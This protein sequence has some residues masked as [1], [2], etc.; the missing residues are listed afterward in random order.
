MHRIQPDRKLREGYMGSMSENGNAANCARQAD[1]FGLEK[2]EA[3]NDA[4][5]RMAA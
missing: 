1:L 3:A 4:E 5:W 2:R